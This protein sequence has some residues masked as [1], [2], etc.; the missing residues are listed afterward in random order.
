MSNF[1]QESTIDYSE[2]TKVEF[3]ALNKLTVFTDD[4]F[5]LQ[6]KLEKINYIDRSSLET[7]QERLT[8][9]ILWTIRAIQNPNKVGRHID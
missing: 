3:D 2:F 7:A 5:E 1:K 8:E 4:L 6:K 9:A